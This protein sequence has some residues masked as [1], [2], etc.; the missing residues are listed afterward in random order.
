MLWGSPGMWPAMCSLKECGKQK[1]ENKK[2]TG[3]AK[4]KAPEYTRN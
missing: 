4:E 2:N 1:L 3:N